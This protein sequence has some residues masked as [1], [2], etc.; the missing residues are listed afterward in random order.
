M[1][2]EIKPPQP[3]ETFPRPLDDMSIDALHDYVGALEAE[4]A[5]V[6]QEIAA[7]EGHRDA[8]ASVFRS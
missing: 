8:A 4:I 2:E 3:E 6:R 5:R 1:D 7:K